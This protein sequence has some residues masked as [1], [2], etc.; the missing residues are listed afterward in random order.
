MTTA[1]STV[2]ATSASEVANSIG[3]VLGIALVL[4]VIVVLVMRSRRKP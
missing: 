4:L 2:Y 3:R 1:L